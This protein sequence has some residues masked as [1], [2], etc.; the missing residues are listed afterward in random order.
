MY[1]IV[2]YF[3]EFHSTLFKNLCYN[4]WYK[5]TDLFILPHFPVANRDF[6]WYLIWNLFFQ[7]FERLFF[8]GITRKNYEKHDN[9]YGEINICHFIVFHIILDNNRGTTFDLYTWLIYTVVLELWYD[10][11]TILTD[12]TKFDYGRMDLKYVI[13]VVMS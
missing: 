3:K 6:Y 1:I 12:F 4:F 7:N 10:L 8:L 2:L 9:I 13:R 11:K 5:Y